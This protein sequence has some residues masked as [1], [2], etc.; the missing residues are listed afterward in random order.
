VRDLIDGKLILLN[1]FQVENQYK[2]FPKEKVLKDYPQI[3]D[4]TEIKNKKGGAR[5]AQDHFN[6]LG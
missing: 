1:P 6:N 4:T 2:G 5:G 3:V